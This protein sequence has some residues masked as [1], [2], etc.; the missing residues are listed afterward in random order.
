MV[1]PIE[2][3]IASEPQVAHHR[4]VQHGERQERHPGARQPPAEGE[5]QRAM[6]SSASAPQSHFECA[7]AEL[8]PWG[9]VK[10]TRDRL[11]EFSRTRVNAVPD[12]NLFDTY[13]I[14]HPVGISICVG[15]LACSAWLC[16][17]ART[18]RG[19][20]TY[21]ALT[22]LMIFPVVFLVMQIVINPPHGGG[23]GEGMLIFLV[24]GPL[25]FAWFLGLPFGLLFRGRRAAILGAALLVI[26]AFLFY[27]FVF[28]L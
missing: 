26:S 20:T 6:M 10:A 27:F 22:I 17:I 16:A 11:R 23:L 5:R 25:A 2:T 24:T 18:W 19:W 4:V 12:F 7:L 3:P 8:G 14:F 28:M 13:S 1:S 15:L 9:H 21:A